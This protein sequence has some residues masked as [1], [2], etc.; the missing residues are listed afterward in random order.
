M[1][2]VATSPESIHIVVAGGDSIGFAAV[3]PSWGALG[4]F[5]ITRPLPERSVTTASTVTTVTEGA[6]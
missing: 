3:C 2:P 5:A 1:V 4:G 6:S